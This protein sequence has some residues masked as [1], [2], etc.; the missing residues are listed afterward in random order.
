MSHAHTHSHPVLAPS[1]NG[2]VVLDIGEGVGALVVHAP[3]ELLGVE[4]EL[5]RRADGLA[6][7]HTE[8][9]ERRLIDGTVY[10]GVFPAVVAGDYTLLDRD[11][12]ARCDLSIAAGTVTEVRW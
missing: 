6:F 4:V 11:G 7:V 3:A 8:V 2:S 5:A 10:A 12:T 1:Y 9:R